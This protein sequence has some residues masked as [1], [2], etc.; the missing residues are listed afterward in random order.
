MSDEF[1]LCRDSMECITE[2]MRIL[3]VG[4]CN[5]HKTESFKSI[6]DCPWYTGYLF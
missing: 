4:E 5:I 1:R 2:Y 3:Y 6:S